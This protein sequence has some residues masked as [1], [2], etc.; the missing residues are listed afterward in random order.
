MVNEQEYIEAKEQYA[1]KILH[2]ID[3]SKE[4]DGFFFKIAD[5]TEKKFVE[6]ADVNDAEN[7]KDGLLLL[8]LLQYRKVANDF[9]NT[10]FR[11]SD[12]IINDKINFVAYNRNTTATQQKQN[13]ADIK[14]NEINKFIDDQIK[15]SANEIINTTQ[16]K[17]SNA[18]LLA[19]GLGLN[20]LEVTGKII[21][22][23]FNASNNYRSKLIALTETQNAAEGSKAI[24]AETY[25]NY[26]NA[27]G[28]GIVTRK[29]WVSLMDGR[30]RVAHGDANGQVRFIGE[31]FEVMGEFLQEPRDLSL[32]ASAGN[33]CGCRCSAIYT[34]K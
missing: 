13:I 27:F 31:P 23:N 29:T 3:L 11:R 7:Y 2:E 15:L 12:K 5:D 22:E 32:G 16:N 17:I 25:N 30:E 9:G 10:V 4:L 6:S 33:T 34:F 1:N 28:A 8:L 26:L 21:R 19:T 18:I 14:Q 24:E 20:D